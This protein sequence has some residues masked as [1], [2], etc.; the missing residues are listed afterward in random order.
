MLVGKGGGRIRPLDGEANSPKESHRTSNTQPLALTSALGQLFFNSAQTRPTVPSHANCEK[1]Q[2]AAKPHAASGSD[3]CKSPILASTDGSTE[4][5]VICEY[6]CIRHPLKQGDRL[7]PL[8]ISFTC[9]DG[10][11]EAHFVRLQLSFKH[12]PEKGLRLL[13]PPTFLT[14]TCEGTAAVNIC[15]DVHAGHVLQLGHRPLPL[16]SL[17]GRA[18]RRVYAKLI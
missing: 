14:S 12:A 2:L 10:C 15:A 7:L 11:V 16:S 9:A 3:C 8:P 6:L 4:A 5:D 17:L 18:D 1:A 13:P